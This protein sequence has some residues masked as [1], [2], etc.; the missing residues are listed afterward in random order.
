MKKVAAYDEWYAEQP[1]WKQQA[2]IQAREG[3]TCK[4][5]LGIGW[6]RDDV[7]IGH[8]AFGRMFKCTKCGG[9]GR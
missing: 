7:P 9:T 2:I 3:K 5:C 4:E 1:F 6:V 8:P